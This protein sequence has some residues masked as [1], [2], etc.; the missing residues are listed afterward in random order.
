MLGFH[1]HK[2]VLLLCATVLRQQHELLKSLA[3]LEESCKGCRKIAN[4]KKLCTKSTLKEY[5]EEA[6]RRVHATP[7]SA[8]KSSNRRILGKWE[9]LF[10]YTHG[11]SDENRV[12]VI[13]YLLAAVV[14]A[15]FSGHP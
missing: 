1:H 12:S 4:R 13:M 8:S 2:S 6:L 10:K 3:A 14:F 5:S 15:N 11:I 9:I 7:T